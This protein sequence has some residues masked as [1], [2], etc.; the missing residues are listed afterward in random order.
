QKTIIG[1]TYVELTP[2]SPSAPAVSDGGMLAR[3][4][5]EPA[6]QLDQIFNALDLV[7]R[8]AFQVWQQQLALALRGNGQNLNSVIG[9]LP[10]F[11]ADANDVVRV[12]DV[13]RTATIRL[14]RNGGTVFAALTQSQP[15]LRNLITSAGTTF[16]TTAAN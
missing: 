7:T 12:L 16:A 13:Q 3:T 2:G 5:V 8:R 4:R 6:V 10:Q 14:I 15:A 1:E 9:N 11:A